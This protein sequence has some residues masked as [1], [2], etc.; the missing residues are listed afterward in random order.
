[1][2][3][4]WD[5]TLSPPDLFQIK[6]KFAPLPLVFLHKDSFNPSLKALGK[7]PL[8]PDNLTTTYPFEGVLTNSLIAEL[9]P[10]CISSNC[11]KILLLALCVFCSF[12]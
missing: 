5:S 11:F 2:I 7:E 4:A 1:M 3:S 8:F 10:G 12:S 9:R 6:F